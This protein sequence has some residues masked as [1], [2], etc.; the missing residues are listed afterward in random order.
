MLQLN[1]H[2]AAHEVYK[3]LQVATK[4]KDTR[5]EMQIK[6]HFISFFVG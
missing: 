2:D 5:P 1:P 4:H 6:K 3:E